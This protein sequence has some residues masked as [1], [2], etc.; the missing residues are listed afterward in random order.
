MG[1]KTDIRNLALRGVVWNWKPVADALPG[2]CGVSDLDGVIERRGHFLILETKRPGEQLPVGQLI[3]L[4]ALAALPNFLVLVVSGDID[5]GVISEYYK[6]EAHG[7]GPRR[8][9]K[10]LPA[11]IARWFDWASN[12]PTVGEKT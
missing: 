7:L 3:M 9:G 11:K 4:K 1:L 5:S 2:R 10:A 6:M 12:A 8:S